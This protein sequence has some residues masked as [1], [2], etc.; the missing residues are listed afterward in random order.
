MSK[1]DDYDFN[2]DAD[3]TGKDSESGTSAHR[4]RRDRRLA[5]EQAEAKTRKKQH[6]AAHKAKNSV[7]AGNEAAVSKG[8]YK[9]NKKQFLKFVIC[10]FLAIA[11]LLTAYAA[12]VIMKAPKIET[13]NIY[14][15]LSQSSTLYDDSGQII[16]NVFADE[17]RTIVSI[18]QIP[19][20]VQKAFIALEDKTFESHHGFNV[21]RIFGAIKDA[22][23]SAA[24]VPSHNSS[25]VICI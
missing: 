24:R 8:R 5:Q 19:D 3:N 11:L 23:I 1:F 14:S 20:Y 13:D 6:Q 12:F 17:N 9:L 16:D 10:I 15:L 18:D 21:V 4:S 7:D 2:N 25:R 22:V